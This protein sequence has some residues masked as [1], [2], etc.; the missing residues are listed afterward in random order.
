MATM[1]N[2]IIADDLQKV[3]DEIV[4]RF[5]PLKIILFGSRAYGTATSNSDAD[6]MVIMNVR[7]PTTYVAARIAAAIPHPLSIDVVVKT[8]TEMEE[9]LHQGNIFETEV[10]KRGILLYEATNDGMD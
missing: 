7:E 9:A 1:S 5:Q 4:R 2:T 6:L 3:V 8:P 10:L